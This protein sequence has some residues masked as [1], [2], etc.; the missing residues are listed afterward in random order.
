MRKAISTLYVHF[1]AQLNLQ[2]DCLAVFVR[3]LMRL[4]ENQGKEPT[5]LDVAKY[6]LELGVT[7]E[8]CGGL[9]DKPGLSPHEII[10]EEIYE[11]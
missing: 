6:P 4:P 5:E 9:C 7:I 1:L 10:K 3:R 11:V 2:I 8:L